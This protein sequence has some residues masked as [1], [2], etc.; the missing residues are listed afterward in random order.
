MKKSTTLLLISVSSSMILGLWLGAWYVGTQQEGMRTFTSQPLADVFSSI[1]ALFAG[2][3]FCGECSIFCVSQVF[4]NLCGH[5]VD[6]QS[7]WLAETVS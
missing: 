3:A 5:P 1:N 7:G 2:F 6:L 4:I